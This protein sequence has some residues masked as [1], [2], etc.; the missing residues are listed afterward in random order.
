LA[1]AAEQPTLHIDSI[2]ILAT[3]SSLMLIGELGKHSLV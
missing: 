2:P 3:F 1:V